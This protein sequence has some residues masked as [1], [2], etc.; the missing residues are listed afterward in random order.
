[1][2]QNAKVYK[3]VG[4]PQQIQQ[5]CW[6]DCLEFNNGKLENG[7]HENLV[8]THWQKE[9]SPGRPLTAHHIIVNI[10]QLILN[11]ATHVDVSILFILILNPAESPPL[12]TATSVMTIIKNGQDHYHITLSTF[13]IISHMW[14][15]SQDPVIDSCNY[16]DARP[17]ADQLFL[18]FCQ[19]SQ[20][21]TSR[22]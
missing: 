2:T 19:N 13:I 1:M 8:I 6:Q 9:T 10:I 3:Q 15:I 4:Y 5:K 20:S 22:C 7:T 16:L 21:Q 14:N 18:T 12:H 11:A 17:E